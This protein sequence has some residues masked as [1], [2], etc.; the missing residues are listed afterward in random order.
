MRSD[1]KL[2]FTGLQFLVEGRTVIRLMFVF[3]SV[4]AMFAAWTA[5][6]RMDT[7]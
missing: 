6:G 5:A 3:N 4:F 7:V 1:E 2:L